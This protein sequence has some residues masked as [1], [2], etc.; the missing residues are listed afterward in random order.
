[1]PSPKPASHKETKV[2]DAIKG[3]FPASDPPATGK[4]T[5]TEPP[6]RPVSRKAPII[7]KEDIESAQRDEGHST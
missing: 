1:M 4:A 7:R 3:S 5:S 2:D 6:A